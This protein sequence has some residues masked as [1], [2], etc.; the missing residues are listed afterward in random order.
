MKNKISIIRDK[1]HDINFE[2]IETHEIFEFY[3]YTDANGNEMITHPNIPS[4]SINRVIVNH[5]GMKI[6]NKDYDN[7]YSLA[8]QKLYTISDVTPVRKVISITINYS[9]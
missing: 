7:V 8:N 5:L 9:V 6:N 4:N 3:I 1:Y 2:S